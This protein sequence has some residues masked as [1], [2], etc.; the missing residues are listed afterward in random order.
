VKIFFLLLILVIAFL[1]P[2]EN[3]LSLKMA[4][5][6]SIPTIIW[7]LIF[8]SIM[9]VSG[10]AGLNFDIDYKQPRLSSK[11]NARNPFTYIY[12]LSLV[13]L[14]FGLGSLISDYI[15]SKEL[16]YI[17]LL[18]IVFGISSLIGIVITI[19]RKRK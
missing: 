1:Y 6:I 14:S 19:K 2:I 11:L 4:L 18:L 13:C 5:Y 12:F 8:S 17:S 3:S 9:I 15:F 10:V 7:G 16:N